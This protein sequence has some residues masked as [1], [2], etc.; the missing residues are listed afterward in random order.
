MFTNFRVKPRTQKNAVKSHENDEMM[1]QAQMNK[2][3]T[4]TYECTDVLNERMGKHVQCIKERIYS[5][6][7]QQYARAWDFQNS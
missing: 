7:P 3:K 6:E 4:H 1:K 5:Q 2:T